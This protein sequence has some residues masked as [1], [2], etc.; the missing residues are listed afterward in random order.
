MPDDFDSDDDILLELD[1]ETALAPVQPDPEPEYS[2]GA[3]AV[4]I[5][6]EREPDEFARPCPCGRGVRRGRMCMH[7]WTDYPTGK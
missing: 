5:D 7:C 1:G 2:P 4:M 3:I 6:Y